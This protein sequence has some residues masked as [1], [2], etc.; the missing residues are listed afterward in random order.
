MPYA[1][2]RSHFARLLPQNIFGPYHIAADCQPSVR[3]FQDSSGFPYNYIMANLKNRPGSFGSYLRWKTQE[4]R[5]LWNICVN[6]RTTWRWNSKEHDVTVWSLAQGDGVYE[7]GCNPSNQAAIFKTK[8]KLL[9]YQIYWF[10]IS[11]FWHVK[12]TTQPQ[13]NTISCSWT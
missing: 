1:D 5:P 8:E 7:Y 4:E 10:I 12:P 2:V 3:H 13:E 6:G 11:P 9:A